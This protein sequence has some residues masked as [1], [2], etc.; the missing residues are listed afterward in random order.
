VADERY[1]T[2][3]KRDGPNLPISR[4]FLSRRA[5]PT[6]LWCVSPLD[7][8]ISLTLDQP[9]MNLFRRGG[10][11][12]YDI[13]IETKPAGATSE[14]DFDQKLRKLTQLKEAHGI[15]NTVTEV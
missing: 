8:N 15:T 12:I 5:I 2:L 9:P 7:P 1:R 6:P 11:P 14:P 13:D 10:A 3:W 4:A